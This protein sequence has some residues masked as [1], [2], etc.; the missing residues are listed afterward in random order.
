MNIGDITNWV[1][2]SPKHWL[3]ILVATSALLFL[4]D[5]L[6]TR[7]GAEVVVKQHRMWIGL[8]WLVACAM[9]VA[10]ALQAVGGR[11]AMIVRTRRFL[12][13]G[14]DALRKLTPEEKRL[15]ADYVLSDSKSQNLDLR[16]GVV[17]GLV[18]AQI[19]YRSSNMGD[20][21]RGFAYNVQPWAWEELKANPG[22]LE[23]ELSNR[24][25]ELQAEIARRRR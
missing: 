17:N 24:L 23:P 2:L 5:G 1:K 8:A 19:I 14:R 4:P 15:L 25:E 9:L 12:K 16:S 21:L 13:T 3:S 10:H 22:L 20:L 7:L 11:G 18:Q 6:L